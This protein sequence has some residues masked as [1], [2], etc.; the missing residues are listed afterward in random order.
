MMI[1]Y[2]DIHGQFT[3]PLPLV[4]QNMLTALIQSQQPELQLQSLFQ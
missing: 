1:P 2:P 4:K 3:A